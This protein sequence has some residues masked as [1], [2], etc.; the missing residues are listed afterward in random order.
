MVETI[1]TPEAFGGR[2]WLSVLLCRIRTQGTF[3]FTQ[4]CGV[5]WGPSL[6]WQLTLVLEGQ[7]PEWPGLFKRAAVYVSTRPYLALECKDLL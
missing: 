1:H 6:E 5:C 4:Q 2:A 7:N 3:L